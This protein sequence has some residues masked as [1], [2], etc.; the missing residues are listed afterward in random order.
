MNNVS[1][2][3][4]YTL[5]PRKISCIDDS[6]TGTKYKVY[7]NVIMTQGCDDKRL[8]YLPSEQLETINV[9]LTLVQYYKSGSSY[10]KS[11]L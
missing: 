1:T 8:T 10:V 3:K 5:R 11:H 6:T 9:N 7:K 4:L 2:M